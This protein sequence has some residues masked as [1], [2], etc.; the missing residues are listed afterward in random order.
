MR[1]LGASALL[2]A[3]A[4]GCLLLPRLVAERRLPAERAYGSLPRAFAAALRTAREAC[5]SDGLAPASVRALARLYQANRLDAEARACYAVVATGSGGLGA[6]DHYFLS[7]MDQYAGDLDGAERELRATAAADPAY[8]PARLALA[9]VLFKSGQPEAAERE[10]QALLALD[11]HQPQALFA[12]SR[13]AL[14]RGDDG[15]ALARLNDLLSIHPEMTS[16]AA[17]L[18]QVLDRRGESARAEVMRRWSRQKPEP[19]PPDPWADELLGD[20]Y[21]TQRL[22]LKYEEYITSGEL[23]RATPFMSRVE[24]LDPGSP[25]PS[26]VR[27]WTHARAHEDA[28]AVEDYRKSLKLGG[29]PEKLGP[30]MAE[31]LLALGRTDEALDELARLTARKP[32]S[33]P[34]LTSY[35]GAALRKG[36][37]ALARRLLEGVLAREPYLPDPNMSLARILWSAGD[38]DGAAKCLLRVAETSPGD[39]P[40]RALLGEYYLGR[41]EPAA[42]APYLELALGRSQGEPDRTRE[43]GAQLLRAYMDAG[44]AEDDAGRTAEALSRYYDKAALLAP[45]DPGVHARRAEAA[46]RVG[47]LD[48]AADSLKRLAGLQPS[49][50]TIVL[51]LGD[52]LYHRGDREGARLNWERALTLAAPAD[53]DLRSALGA[54]LNGPITEATFK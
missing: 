26:L 7:E 38:R 15:A 9:D 23:G 53:A 43:L 51:S 35:S 17:L 47:D 3:A 2:C 13:I 4:L 21:D 6:H 11:P 28:E 40:S 16:G 32:D 18:A 45:A 52:V 24:L 5:L 19:V 27:G 36:D 42:A 22:A 12:L 54:R 33:I 20:C 14:Q 46:A 31:S 34:L 8:A 1:I 10:Y 50:P 41:S 49:N 37:T 25:V 44:R 39:V 30:Y 48:R 29:D